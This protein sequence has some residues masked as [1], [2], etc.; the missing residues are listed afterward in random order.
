MVIAIYL[1][2]TENVNFIIINNEVTCHALTAPTKKGSVSRACVGWIKKNAADSSSLP[3]TYRRTCIES[4]SPSKRSLDRAMEMQ[5]I[6]F[7][8]N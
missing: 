8:Y 6:Y 3:S 7:V 2:P 4:S 5:F 1:V